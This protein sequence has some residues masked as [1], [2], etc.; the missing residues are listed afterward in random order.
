[1]LLNNLH[2]TYV[3]EN[4]D[5]YSSIIKVRLIPIFN[6]AINACVSVFDKQQEYNNL[7][8]FLRDI[9]NTF[10]KLKDIDYLINKNSENKVNNLPNPNFLSGLCG[11]GGF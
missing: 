2:N 7:D 4:Q 8:G 11:E 9:M 3:L 10:N 6:R 1:M 5:D